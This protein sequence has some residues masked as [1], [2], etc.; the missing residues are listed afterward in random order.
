VANVIFQ[1][2]IGLQANLGHSG[3]LRLHRGQQQMKKNIASTISL[4]LFRV[5]IGLFIVLAGIFLALIGLG[6]LR[7]TASSVQASKT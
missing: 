3:S 7:L 2:E 1:Q 4:P 6:V 5:L